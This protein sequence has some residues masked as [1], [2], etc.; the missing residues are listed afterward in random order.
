MWPGEAFYVPDPREL[1]VANTLRL[2]NA[3]VSP[4]KALS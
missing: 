2:S 3:A 4:R 1:P